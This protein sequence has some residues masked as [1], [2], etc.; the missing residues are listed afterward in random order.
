MYYLS[1]YMVLK[2]YFCKGES[3]QYEKSKSL[4]YDIKCTEV[5]KLHVK[6]NDEIPMFPWCQLIIGA[7]DS[8][9]YF[10]CGFVFN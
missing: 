1:K 7:A 4:K 9:I 5:I 2:C 10:E 8:L 3:Q 6:E